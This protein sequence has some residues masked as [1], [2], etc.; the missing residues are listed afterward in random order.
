MSSPWITKSGIQ[1]NSTSPAVDDLYQSPNVFINGVPVVLYNPPGDS[2]AVAAITLATVSNDEVYFSKGP[3]AAK[4]YIQSLVTAG[5][6]TQAEVDAGTAAAAALSTSTA[7]VTA[8]FA[9]TSVAADCK[10]IHGLT[11]FPDSLVLTPKGTTLGDLLRKVTFPNHNI[12]AQKGLTKDQIVCNLANLAQNIYEPL[13]AQFPDVFITNTFREGE[14]QSQ[15]GTGQAMD[16]QFHR[17]PSKDY[18][19]RA[20][21]IKANLPYDQLLLECHTSGA[22]WIHVSHYSG[23]G[24]NVH[25]KSQGNWYATM[26]NDKDFTP[27]LRDL[28][29]VPG[30]RPV[31]AA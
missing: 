20:E 23:T 16:I 13:K 21:W 17:L 26:I 14:N 28:S 11:S 10:A 29:V 24:I 25:A 7:A 4:Q 27:G 31:P 1:K 30:V 18:L 22:L 3:E 19:A 5:V 6:M 8:D 12:V 9:G 15:H 2:P